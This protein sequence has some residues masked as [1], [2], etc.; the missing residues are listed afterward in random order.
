MHF[1]SKSYE[2]KEEEDFVKYRN[3]VATTSSLFVKNF[4]NFN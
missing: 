1:R 3:S 2:I 4:S